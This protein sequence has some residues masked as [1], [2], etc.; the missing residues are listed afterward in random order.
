MFNFARRKWVLVT[1]AFCLL[2][3][4]IYLLIFSHGGSDMGLYYDYATHM[5]NGLVP[6]RDFT[7]EYPPIALALFYLPYVL[8]QDI[9]SYSN[10]FADEMMLFGIAGIWLVLGLARQLRI[11]PL[12]ALSCYTLAVV[13]IGDI[14]VQRFD[15]VPAVITLAALYAFCRGKY[16]V[17][18]LVLAIGVM[19]KL[20]PVVLAPIFLIYQWR[21]CN[22]RRIWQS[23]AVFVLTLMLIAAPALVLGKG[24]FINSFTVQSDRALQLESLYASLLLL[25]NSLGIVD[26]VAV[27]GEMS[28]D[29]SS[30]LAA[31]LAKYAFLVVGAALLAIYMLF[32]RRISRKFEKPI[33][34]RISRKLEKPTCAMLDA[35]DSASVIHYAIAVITVFIITNKVFSPQFV[36]WLCP[37]IPLVSGRWHKVVWVVFLLVACLTWYVYPLNYFVLADG[38]QVVMNALILRNVLLILLVVLLVLN[39]SRTQT[40]SDGLPE[41]AV[42]AD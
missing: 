20:Y 26:A 29:V 12:I 24:G 17:A 32:I 16:E 19:T 11:S 10:V 28:F 6:Y 40:A 8:A 27:R 4:V 15:L 5:G 31:P 21:R 1:L 23:L 41:L 9:S 39:P 13:A 34:R 3:M 7:V 30:P 2:H 38:Q 36:L 33:I 14:A 18:W 35:A 42:A 37:L 25:L 22:R